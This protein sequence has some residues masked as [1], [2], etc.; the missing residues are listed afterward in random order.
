MKVGRP[1][2]CVMAI[3]Q[4]SREDV[5]DK[6]KVDELHSWVQGKG[7]KKKATATTAPQA[8]DSGEISHL[9]LWPVCP[10]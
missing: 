8:G 2:L 10:A 3:L 5:S 9:L 6:L 1:F 4:L 7:F